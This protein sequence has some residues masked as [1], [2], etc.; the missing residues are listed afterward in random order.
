MNVEN[1]LENGSANIPSIPGKSK[2]LKFWASAF[3]TDGIILGLM[4]L[5]IFKGSEGAGNVFK[6]VTWTSVTLVVLSVLLTS[7]KT[8][9][10]ATYRPKGFKTYHIATDVF[11]IIILAWN[12]HLVLASAF[13][14]KFI[15]YESLRSHGVNLARKSKKRSNTLPNLIKIEG[16]MVTFADMASLKEAQLQLG[17]YTEVFDLE[18]CSPA[19]LEVLLNKEIVDAVILGNGYFSNLDELYAIFSKHPKVKFFLIL[20]A[21]ESRL[22][23]SKSRSVFNNN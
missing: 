1:T 23:V 21:K 19:M 5:W 17:V 22:D 10:V 18:H 12:A 4:L 9:V 16:D 13:I 6:L 20:N 14:I 2:A 8:S 11:A 7:S 15:I 3:I